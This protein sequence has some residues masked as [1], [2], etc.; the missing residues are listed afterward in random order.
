MEMKRQITVYNT[1]PEGLDALK[2]SSGTVHHSKQKA[3]AVDYLGEKYT[4]KFTPQA[5]VS[6]KDWRPLNE[7]EIACL[8]PPENRDYLNTIYLGV[9]PDEL[10]ECFETLQLDESLH[11]RDMFFRLEKDPEAVKKATALMNDFLLPM[12]NNEPFHYHCMGVN[13]PNLELVAANTVMLPQDHVA[14]DRVLIGLHNDGLQE[15]TIE[16][17]HS[18]ENRISINL[19]K[20]SRYFLFV[21]LYLTEA[22]KM[23]KEC[24]SPD[25]FE[26]VNI[27]NIPKYFFKYFPDYPVIRVEQ[28][29]YQ[30]YIAATFNCFHDGSTLGSTH[31]D[32]TMVYFG[33]FQY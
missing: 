3:A 15:M 22:Y 31:L 24:M 26:L 8:T 17:A 7:D 1:L 29:P 32:V 25:E 12:S 14:S 2:I 18:F 9:I 10:R 21:N 11:R 6:K 28:K 4:P 16:T 30:Y 19:G 20:D 5:Y 13:N 33:K 27:S 23:L